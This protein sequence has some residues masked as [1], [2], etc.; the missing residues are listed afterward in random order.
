MGSEAKYLICFGIFVTLAL[1][2]LRGG[3]S[4]LI[5]SVVRPM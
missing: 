3:I 1:Y 2:A 5:H 4:A